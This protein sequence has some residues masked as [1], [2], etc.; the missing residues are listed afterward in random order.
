MQVGA[1]GRDEYCTPAWLTALVG[2]VDIDPCSNPRSHV[3]AEFTVSAEDGDGLTMTTHSSA[4]VFVNPPYSRGQVIRWVSH[5]LHTRFIFLLRWDPSTEWFRVLFPRC[6]HVWFPYRRIQFDP[7]PGV[8]A[9][10]NPYPHALYLHDP[11]PELLRRLR[12]AGYL[13]TMGAPRGQ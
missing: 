2:P 4:V 9:S 11:S 6:S 8:T 13:L 1:S 10:S 12:G 5:F 3:Q 7:P